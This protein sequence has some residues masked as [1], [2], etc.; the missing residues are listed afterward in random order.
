M[1][2]NEITSIR[3]EAQINAVFNKMRRYNQKLLNEATTTVPTQ[4]TP[5]AAWYSKGFKIFASAITGLRKIGVTAAFL[6]PIY[7]YVSQMQLAEERL[8]KTGD[9]AQY[10]SFNQMHAG[11]M[12]AGLAANLGV[13]FTSFVGN[14]VIASMLSFIP[15]FGPL[16]AGAYRLLSSAGQAYVMHKLSTAEGKEQIATLIGVS[17]VT[18][19]GDFGVAAI[20]WLQ[21]VF[22]EAI[23]IQ[24][25]PVT[26]LKT[27][28]PANPEK[29][30]ENEP[31][32]PT[33]PNKTN[34]YM[35]PRIDDPQNNYTPPGFRRDENGYLTYD[36]LQ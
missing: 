8:I 13:V 28:E 36:K 9:V 6:E 34:N 22:S 1:R 5:A 27:G 24:S 32:D 17:T 14:S 20:D 23:G 2:I 12:I 35:I 21:Q 7:H 26:P 16:L 10:N 30:P 31:I 3:T 18:S 19:M 29:Q 25:K 33:K 15:F 11:Q 4:P